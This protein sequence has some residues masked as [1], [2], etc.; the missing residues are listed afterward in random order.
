MSGETIVVN[1]GR[2]TVY[3]FNSKWLDLAMF[4]F[5]FCFDPL[6]SYDFLQSM[7]I[8]LSSGGTRRF[9]FKTAPLQEAED[10]SSLE[11]V[12][13]SMDT[14][15]KQ[16]LSCWGPLQHRLTVQGTDDVYIQTKDRMKKAEQERQGQK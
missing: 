8:P 12:H 9:D 2:D 5:F 10:H 3:D 13:Q 7:A 16:A 4:F 15:R 6:L 11:C 1:N 14:S